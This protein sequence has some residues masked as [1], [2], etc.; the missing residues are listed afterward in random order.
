[1]VANVLLTRH[2]DI[3][4][5]YHDNSVRMNQQV[6]EHIEASKAEL[7]RIWRE[8]SA[9]QRGAANH[10]K[11]LACTAELELPHSVMARIRD[12]PHAISED[13]YQGE[14]RTI[15]YTVKFP[16]G[17]QM[18]IKC[19]GCQDA[20]SWTEAVL[21]EEYGR[22]LCCT[23]PADTFDGPWQLQFQDINYIVVIKAKNT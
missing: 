3:I 20:A 19:C 8:Y 11:N 21:F 14:D 18:D 2:G 22:Q 13:E 15:T 9:A 5:D 12:Y 4:V 10:I 7:R 1:M 23:E 16:D 6:L 17:K